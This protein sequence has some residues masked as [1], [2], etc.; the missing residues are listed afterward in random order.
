M[1]WTTFPLSVSVS[2]CFMVYLAMALVCTSITG[3]SI[4]PCLGSQL[5]CV[6]HWF[7]IWSAWPFLS[8]VY[9]Q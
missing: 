5:V 6:N 1:V 8:L 2:V 7:V 9:V 3:H 4:S